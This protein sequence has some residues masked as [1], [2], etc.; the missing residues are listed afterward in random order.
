M[1][2]SHPGSENPSWKGGRSTN[3]GHIT[4]T[5]PPG[6]PRT[7]NRGYVREHI[8]MVERVLGHYLLPPHVVH[9]VDGN[10]THNE[11]SNFVACED[12]SYH[13][14]LHARKRA[15]EGCGHPDWR[16]CCFCHQ[17]DNTSNMRYSAGSRHHVH[18][19]CE[20]EYEIRRRNV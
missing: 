5:A 10:K 8:L 7:D 19:K 17:Y 11:N 9:H 13:Q 20:Y 16:M 4:V 2:M 14:L 6:H 15:L 1:P 18:R 3:R 12:E